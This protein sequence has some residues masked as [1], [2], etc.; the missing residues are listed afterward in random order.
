MSVA[1]FIADQRTFY[2][3][4]HAFTCRVGRRALLDGG[5]A[6]TARSRSTVR[7]SALAGTPRSGPAESWSVTRLYSSST[8]LRSRAPDPAV[9]ARRV[10]QTGAA[11]GVT[12]PH[13]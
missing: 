10:R 9:F 1:R 4:P 6:S 11:A 5:S 2:R 13:Q 7:T 3:V 8:F 12:R